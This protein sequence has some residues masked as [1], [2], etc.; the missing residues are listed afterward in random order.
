MKRYKKIISKIPSIGFLAYAS[1]I[2]CVVS[3]II[4]AVSFDIT[5]PYLSISGVMLND[6]ISH[7]F[8]S[9]HYWSA[10]FSLILFLL[11]IIDHLIRKSEFDIKKGMWLRLTLVIPLVFYL[12]FSGFL[13]RADSDAL[14][15]RNIAENVLLSVPFV[16][17]FLKKIFFGNGEN[18]IVVYIHHISTVTIIV[19]LSTIEHSKKIMPNAKYII[20]MIIPV[21]LFSFFLVPLLNIPD[22]AII[23]G[24]WYFVG[25]QEILHWFSEPIWLMII[26]FLVSILIYL[27]PRFKKKIN[28]NI[29]YLLSVIALLYIVL[30]ITAFYFRYENWEFGLPWGT[31]QI[32][33]FMNYNSYIIEADIGIKSP[34]II[35]GK[36][37][38]CLYCHTATGFTKSHDISIV[39]CSGCHLGNSLTLNKKTAH[40]DMILIPGNLENAKQTCGK[41][42]CHPEQVTR[43]N[44]SLMNTMSGIIAVDKWVFDESNDLNIKYNIKNIKDSPA[45]KHLKNLCASCHLSKRKNQFGPINELSRGGGCNA[46]HLKYVEKS[47]KELHKYK[48]SKTIIDDIIFYHPQLTI[49]TNNNQCFGCHSRSGRISLS[50]EGWHE[51]KLEKLPDN[52]NYRKLMDVRILEKHL[53]DI[54]FERGMIC[55]DCHVSYEIMGDG[56]SYSHKE[57]QVKI[58]CEDCHNP[59]RLKL[60]AYDKIDY[61][62]QRIIDL[63]DLYKKDRKFLVSKSGLVYSN[64]FLE[65]N[66][67]VLKTKNKDTLLYPKPFVEKCGKD[68]NG[69]KS[70]SCKSCHNQWSPQCIGCHTKYEPNEFGYNNLMDKKEKGAWIEYDG[71]FIAEQP[72]LGVNDSKDRTVET[73]I[74]GMVLTIQQ[75]KKKVFKRLFS[76]AFSH[77]IRKESGTCK[78]CHYNSNTIG[79]GRGSMTRGELVLDNKK[80]TISFKGKYQ[81]LIYDNLPED[82][83]VG[84]LKNPI[85]KSS[86][87]KNHRSFNIEEQKRILN[88]GVCFSCHDENNQTFLK[89]FENSNWKEKLSKKCILLFQ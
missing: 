72:V 66:M 64:V 81:N 60:I 7:L 78:S 71:I 61:E 50:F 36:V 18:L 21:L 84:F 27:L 39:G 43:V 88:I 76:P 25:I 24:P 34:A 86:T 49:K 56:K 80:Q 29:K 40:D 11:H 65:N 69:H 38:G 48:K 58:T 4:L 52:I 41:V 37:E 33:N 35:R 51:T 77:T 2:I 85:P 32:N 73:F 23:K 31:H 42:G 12:M 82:A 62:T 70:L 9:I 57:E 44:N 74:P 15:A 47:L 14:Q 75:D 83:W 20:Y 68:I 16:G 79:F 63:R 46:C 59:E 45:D 13:L 87:R 17:D 3:G 54:H 19:W 1:F 6:I 22:S 30:T 53:P 89:I 10:Q 55:I 5:Q 26:M 67:L 8:R 28:K